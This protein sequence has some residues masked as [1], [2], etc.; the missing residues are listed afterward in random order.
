MTPNALAEVIHAR[1][2]AQAGRFMVGIAGPPASGKSTLTAA[3]AQALGPVS[4]V[5]PMD[6]YHF[7][8]AVLRARGHLSRKGAPH[9]FDTS[10]LSQTL[11]RIRAGEEVAI[12]IFDRA[13]E[14]SRSGAAVVGDA[15][16]IILVEGNY[17]LLKNAPWNG[18]HELF[19]MTVMIT[20]PESVLIERLARR[21]SSFGRNDG[22]DW[23][24]SNDLPNIR[25]VL[26]E[27]NSA[28]IEIPA[29]DWP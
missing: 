5:V 10:G 11:R 9:T 25:I 14:L 24:K 19:D 22:P 23:I 7:D 20:A 12:P 13:L 21:W 6:G 2:K 17:L 8:D 16:R 26:T 4:A 18:L 28:D 1:A 27:S 3:L 29:K 15:Q